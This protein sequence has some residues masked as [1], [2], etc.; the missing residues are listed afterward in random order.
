MEVNL[1]R[2][3]CGDK[4]R[5]VDDHGEKGIVCIGLGCNIVMGGFKTFKQAARFWNAGMDRL[6][7]DEGD[8]D[9]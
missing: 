1:S 6:T 7:N 5:L 2:C 9:D 8:D 3:L 4:P